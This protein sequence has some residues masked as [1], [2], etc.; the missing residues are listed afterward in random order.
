MNFNPRPRKEGD[1]RF[2]VYIITY[3]CISIHAL[4]KRATDNFAKVK[5]TLLISIHA[6]VKRA[7]LRCIPYAPSGVISIHALVKRATFCQN[8]ATQQAIDFNPRPRKEGDI[9]AVGNWKI[10]G[11]FQSTPS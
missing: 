5:L 1:S 6:L 4:V 11:I 10:I 7:T 9:F 2:I 8:M 3:L